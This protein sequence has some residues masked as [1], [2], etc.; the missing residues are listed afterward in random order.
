MGDKTQ[1][2]AL[3]FATRYRPKLVLIGITI[4]TLLVHLFSVTIGEVLGASLPSF[5]ISIAAGLAFIGFG[6]WTL[7]GDELDDEGEVKEHALGPLFTV[8]ITFFLA[9]LGDKTM[10]A[11]VT[12]SSEYRDFVPVWIGSTL[13]MVLAD[14]LA[15]I[16]GIVAGKRLPEKTIQ[17]VA[18]L[19]FIGTGI[20][21][22][23]ETIFL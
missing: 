9:E 21:T 13:G 6:I 14:G 16:V 7:R 20:F 22:L 11:T 5:W 4:A 19:I 2:V 3:A 12:L 15:V 1:L 23:V 17:I 18:A 8:G 10:L